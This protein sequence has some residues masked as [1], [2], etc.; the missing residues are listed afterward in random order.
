MATPDEAS[1]RPTFIAN[2]AIRKKRPAPE[3]AEDPVSQIQD[4]V[5]GVVCGTAPPLK[6]V[7]GGKNLLAVAEG[8]FVEGPADPDAAQAVVKPEFGS[9]DQQFANRELMSELGRRS[10]AVF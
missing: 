7:T 2:G 4:E 6:S 9:H 1:R 8:V 5:R 10:R 3:S